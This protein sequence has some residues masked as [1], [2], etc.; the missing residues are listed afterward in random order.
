[1]ELPK[2]SGKDYYVLALILLPVSVVLSYAVMGNILFANVKV[3]VT[4][5]A[6]MAA[7]LACYFI[8][9]GWWALLMK[10]RFPSEAD[11]SK[12]LFFMIMAFLIMSGLVMLLVFQLFDHYVFLNYTIDSGRFLWSYVGLGFVNIFLS[13][14]FEGI[15]R[16]EE[17]KANLQRQKQLQRA[18]HQSQLQALRSQVNPHFLFNCM[19]S[20]SCLIEEDPVAAER[21][22]DEMSQVYRYMLRPETE[23]LVTVRA[24]IQFLRSYLCL[25][26]MRFGDSL[27]TNIH[28]DPSLTEARLPALTLQMIIEQVI[29]QNTMSK[30]EPLTIEINLSSE[31]YAQV[32]HNLNPKQKSEK[33]EYEKRWTNLMSDHRLPEEQQIFVN[34]ENEVRTLRIPIQKATVK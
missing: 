4:A 8:L 29:S 10:Q 30:K 26:T 20:L 6:I 17:W 32:R 2:Y 18:F 15:A 28:V 27:K 31:G 12:K 33:L 11:I 7:V 24:E 1:M 14:L 21:F 9:C 5:T 22:L 23:Q 34:E 13:F 16:F 25:L 3:F 19:N